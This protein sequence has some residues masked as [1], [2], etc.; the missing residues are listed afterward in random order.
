MDIDVEWKNW[1]SL[2]P[3]LKEDAHHAE[4]IDIRDGSVV[5]DTTIHS[6]WDYLVDYEVAVRNRYL[7]SRKDGVIHRSDVGD[8]F[9]TTDWSKH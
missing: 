1:K 7:N 2:T 8:A 5:K 9:C 6:D 3:Y 4:I